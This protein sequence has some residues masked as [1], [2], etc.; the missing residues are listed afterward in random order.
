[1]LVGLEFDFNLSC[2]FLQF[3]CIAQVGHKT[4]K[5]IALSKSI[6]FGHSVS[7]V[8][9]SN[10][11]QAFRFLQPLEESEVCRPILHGYLKTEMM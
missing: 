3:K 11:H 1:M 9:Q 5:A 4:S 2:L 7:L 6:D 10:S 8:R